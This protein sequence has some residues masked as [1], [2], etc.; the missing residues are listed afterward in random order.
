[1]TCGIRL[2][3]LALLGEKSFVLTGVFIAKNETPGMLS[4]QGSV[5]F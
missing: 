1:M 3:L 2:L 4:S 5:P